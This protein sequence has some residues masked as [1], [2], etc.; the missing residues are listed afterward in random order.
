MALNPTPMLNK[1]WGNII[2]RTIC[3]LPSLWMINLQFYSEIVQMINLQFCPDIAGSFVSHQYM[4][5]MHIF[6]YKNIDAII[7]VILSS[8]NSSGNLVNLTFL[9][10]EGDPQAGKSLHEVTLSHPNSHISQ[11]L[12]LRDWRWKAAV[13]LGWM[14]ATFSGSSSWPPRSTTSAT[15]CR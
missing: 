8:A 14:G 1:L 3:H 12:S 6:S 15:L 13:T 11:S 10:F 9:I 2:Y 7:P 5:Y 4:D